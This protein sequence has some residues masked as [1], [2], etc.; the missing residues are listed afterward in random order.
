MNPVIIYSSILVAFILIIAI[1]TSYLYSTQLL[2]FPSYQPPISSIRIDSIDLASGEA[3]ITNLAGVR[4]DAAIVVRYVKQ[5][6]GLDMQIIPVS[7]NPGQNIVKIQTLGRIV[8][9]YITVGGKWFKLL[10]GYLVETPRIDVKT[11]NINY[12]YSGIGTWDPRYWGQGYATTYIDQRVIPASVTLSLSGGYYRDVCNKYIY[13]RT[14][15]VVYG[16]FCKQ[17]GTASGSILYCLPCPNQSSTQAISSANPPC[18]VAR[19]RGGDIVPQQ[20]DEC[21][22]SCNPISCPDYESIEDRRETTRTYICTDPYP[23]LWLDTISLSG[24]TSIELPKIQDIAGQ[25]MLGGF[26]SFITNENSTSPTY[27]VKID[28]RYCRYIYREYEHTAN[29]YSYECGGGACDGADATGCSEDIRLVFEEER[30][31]CE[32]KQCAALK[33]FLTFSIKPYD[34]GIVNVSARLSR[35]YEASYSPLPFVVLDLNTSQVIS[36]SFKPEDPNFAIDPDYGDTVLRLYLEIRARYFIPGIKALFGIRYN[37]FLN[38]VNTYYAVIVGG[39]N[40]ETQILQGSPQL[41]STQF[42]GASIPRNIPLQINSIGYIS[43]PLAG[44][45]A[46]FYWISTDTAILDITARYVFVIALRN[47]ADPSALATNTGSFLAKTH[48]RI[49]LIP[50]LS[51]GVT[52]V[53]KTIQG[54]G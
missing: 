39:S 17:I 50:I 38:N 21:Y 23:C 27:A 41:F 43:N 40:I 14:V 19:S 22:C 25:I 1:S 6:G 7:L 36:Y 20:G 45:N 34:L 53:E 2:S 32:G 28:Q 18:S 10:P 33:N 5:G 24:S 37:E 3:I 31:G 47:T 8:D 15:Q 46:K 9:S 44:A 16:T 4:Y 48:L 42:L 26:K 13:T 11:R 12:T 54:I 51:I 35:S 49:Y 30:D 52:S 29:T